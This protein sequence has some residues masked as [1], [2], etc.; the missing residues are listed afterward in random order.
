[1][2]DLHCDEPL[3]NGRHVTIRWMVSIYALS[4][5]LVVGAYFVQ[6]GTEEEGVIYPGDVEVTVDLD[7][8]AVGCSDVTADDTSCIATITNNA[9]YTVSLTVTNDL[10]AATVQK[11]FDCELHARSFI[12]VQYTCSFPKT[13]SD[14]AI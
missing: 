6:Y 10:N 13:K 5:S 3:S 12:D 2:E 4:V 8:E 11:T 1:M 14:S 9:N 7:P